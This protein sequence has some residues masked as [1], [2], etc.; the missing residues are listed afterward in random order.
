MRL[1]PRRGDFAIRHTRFASAVLMGVD[2]GR[3]AHARSDGTGGIGFIIPKYAVPSL[4]HDSNDP[5]RDRTIDRTRTS[6]P[7]TVS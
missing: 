3:D 7:V 6:L 1:P 4:K 5:K 2:I